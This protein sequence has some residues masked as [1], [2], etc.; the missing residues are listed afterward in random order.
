M[1]AHGARANQIGI[2]PKQTFECRHVPGDDGIDG[3]LELC[4]GRVGVL[5]RFGMG[6][7]LIPALE[8]V[9][10]RD[11]GTSVTIGVAWSKTTPPCRLHGTGSQHLTM[12]AK[13]RVQRPGIAVDNRLL[14]QLP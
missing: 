2:G 8:M 4:D 5:Q 10:S 1:P 6:S 14:R 9:F 12:L 3:C 13:Q 11:D 7:K